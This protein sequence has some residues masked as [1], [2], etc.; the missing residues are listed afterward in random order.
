[1]GADRANAGG[2]GPEDARS[3]NR[4]TWGKAKSRI[5]VAN[6]PHPPSAL[7]LHLWPVL[8]EESH[9]PGVIRLLSEREDS[10]SEPHC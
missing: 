2:A 3:G 7:P 8:S 6:I 5:S 10:R 9:Q 4:I 1:M